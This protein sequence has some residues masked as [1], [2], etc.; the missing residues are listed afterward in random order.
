MTY[1]NPLLSYGLEKFAE[2]CERIGISGLIIPDLPLE[3]MDS[4]KSTYANRCS[5]CATC[6]FNKS[7]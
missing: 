5:N 3:E 1:Y 4:S 2:D 6:I 7:L